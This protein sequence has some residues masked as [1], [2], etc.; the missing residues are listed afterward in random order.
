LGLIF[1]QVLLS[2]KHLAIEVGEG[3]K[4]PIHHTNSPYSRG[5][6]VQ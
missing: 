2:K 3:N 6:E 5:G 4:I 1:S